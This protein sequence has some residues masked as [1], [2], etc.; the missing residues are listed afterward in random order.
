MRI[1]V[2]CTTF[3]MVLVAAPASAENLKKSWDFYKSGQEALLIYGV[4]ET[5]QVTLSFICE[6]KKKK[7]E[8]IS[9]V[10]P[11]NTR[12]K[13]PGKIKLTNGS[14]SLEYAGKTA[15]GTNDTGIHFGAPI[16][17]EPRLFDLLGTGKSLLIESL[18]ARARVPLVGIKGPLAKMKKAC[19]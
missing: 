12:T 3:A 18:G 4:P 5:E 2:L 9:T 16:A 13:R 7:I 10:M 1:S 19:R 8:I 17:I 15:Q 6:P 11:P 14:S